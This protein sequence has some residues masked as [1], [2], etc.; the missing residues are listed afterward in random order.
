MF[1]AP[2]NVSSS[3]IGPNDITVTWTRPNN[4]VA[5]NSYTPDASTLTW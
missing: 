2:V 5:S 3:S 4:T 1:S